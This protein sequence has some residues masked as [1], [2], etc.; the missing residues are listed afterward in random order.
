MESKEL[1]MTEVFA[2]SIAAVAPSGAMAFNTTTTATVAGINVPIS[3]LLGS[4][5]IL[6][7]GF[8]F[9]E[10]SKNIAGEGSVYAYNKAALGDKAGFITGWALILTYLAYSG[11]VSGIIADIGQVFFKEL[12]INVSTTLIAISSI[13]VA[14]IISFFG[15]KLTTRIALVLEIISILTLTIISTV[16]IIKG[17]AAG[18]S[19]KPL[20]VQ[21]NNLSGIGQGMIFAILCF[22]GFEGSS[23]IAMRSKNPKKAVPF[24]VIATVVIAAIFYIYVSYAQVIGFGI[25]NIHKLATSAAPLDTLAVTYTGK[26]SAIFIDFA[27]F[28]SGF[29]CLLGTLNACAYM[30]HAMSKKGYLFKYLG[31]FNSKLDSPKNAVDTVAIFCLI[32]YATWG[33][34]VGPEEIYT[35]LATLGTLSLL[36]VYMLV[37]LGTIFYFKKNPQLG[38]SFFKH[39][40]IPIFGIVILL[41]PLWSNLYPVPAFP[42]NIMPYIVVIWFLVG[43]WINKKYENMNVIT[44]K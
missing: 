10:M 1:S 18:L 3:F 35:Q 23:T 37:C 16:I 32:I 2:L 12:G 33:S 8:C 44:T 41:I 15:L 6:A 34:I 29:A 7:V 4:I 20:V 22:A 26:L 28:I 38:N 5:A 31:K 27:T 39:V 30:L 25:S 9:A 42:L 24:A 36:I 13:L 43:F 11:G 40:L 19:M 17:G 21:G 14:W